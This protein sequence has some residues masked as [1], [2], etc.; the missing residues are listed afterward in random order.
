MMRTQNRKI[1]EC[2]Q[3]KQTIREVFV[4]L[5]ALLAVVLRSRGRATPP[6]IMVAAAVEVEVV[7]VVAVLLPPRGRAC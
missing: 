6:A 2:E 4:Q 1:T 7:V 5:H 3:S